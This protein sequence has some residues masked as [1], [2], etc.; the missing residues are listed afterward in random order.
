MSFMTTLFYQ[1]DSLLD[2]LLNAALN[3][4]I[5]LGE[6]ERSLRILFNISS[7]VGHVEKSEI[8]ETSEITKL[9]VQQ[10]NYKF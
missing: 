1:Q 4:F 8:A 3:I 2:I 7:L 9:A 5:V 6:S 10:G